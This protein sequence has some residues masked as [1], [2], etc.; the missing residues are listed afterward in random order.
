MEIKSDFVLRNPPRTQLIA[1]LTF[2]EIALAFE[3]NESTH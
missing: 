1:L 3:L 2:N